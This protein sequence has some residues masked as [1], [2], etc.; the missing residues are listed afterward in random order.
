MSICHNLSSQPGSGFSCKL[1]HFQ[2]DKPS[3]KKY[4]TEWGEKWWPL[5]WFLNQINKRTNARYWKHQTGGFVMAVTH[6]KERPLVSPS[7]D[8]SLKPPSTITSLSL[9]G[10][11]THCPYKASEAEDQWNHH[12]RHH[13]A[14][15]LLS[16]H[17]YFSILAFSGHVEHL[18]SSTQPQTLGKK[19]RSWHWWREE[20]MGKNMIWTA[21]LLKM[22]RRTKGVKGRQLQY[23]IYF[24]QSVQTKNDLEFTNMVV[25]F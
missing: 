6:A 7:P 20:V 8:H 24:L 17:C 12:S 14:H 10:T 21:I 19:E 2:T 13:H 22:T 16:F 3:K 15:C 1:N 18:T 4:C 25:Y 11:E 5:F 23:E 9:G